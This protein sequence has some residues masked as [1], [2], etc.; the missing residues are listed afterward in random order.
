MLVRQVLRVGDRLVGQLTFVHVQSGAQ[1]WIGC[2]RLQRPLL[3]QRN[4]EWHRRIVQRKRRGVGH[5][6]GHIGD[7]VMHHVVQHIGRMGVGGRT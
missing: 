7:A 6:A 3:G 2:H 5:P 4:G 1:M